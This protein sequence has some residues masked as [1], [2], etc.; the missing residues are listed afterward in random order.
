MLYNALSI[1]VIFIRKPLTTSLL[2]DFINMINGDIGVVTET[3]PDFQRSTK[4]ARSVC[5]LVSCNGDVFRGKKLW[6]RQSVLH[7]FLK[8]RADIYAEN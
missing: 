8:E 1:E 5:Y 2:T 3:G 6:A 7:S 4:V